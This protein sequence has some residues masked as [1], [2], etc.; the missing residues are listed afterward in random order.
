M[1]CSKYLQSFSQ[2][3]MKN[4]AF[5]QAASP[6]SK[7][8][9]TC[10]LP[11]VSPISGLNHQY[12]SFSKI[13]ILV[14][15]FLCLSTAFLPL[16]TATA[17]AT[18][19]PAEPVNLA[20]LLQK[21]LSSNHQIRAAA[22]QSLNTIAPEVK[23][24]VLTKA[25]SD[26]NWKIQAVAAYNL[27]Q[28]GSNARSAI[29]AL[30]AALDSP[31]PDVRFTVAK[32]LGQIGSEVAVP[33]LA[34]ALE[35]KDENVRMAAAIALDK[36]GPD[37]QAALPVL[38]KSLRDGNWFVRSHAAA[39]FVRLAANSKSIFP[40]LLKRLAKSTPDD[41]QIDDSRGEDQIPTVVAIEAL[42]EMGPEIVPDLLKSLKN[43][44]DMYYESSALALISLGSKT[45][46]DK[47]VELLIQT[48][49]D[50]DD[51]EFSKHLGLCLGWIGSKAAIPSLV[52]KKD[53]QALGLIGF[54]IIL[55]QKYVDY[56]S[57]KERL[58]YKKVIPTLAFQLK[59]EDWQVRATAIAAMALVSKDLA[60]EM[61]IIPYLQS[62]LGD[63]DRRVRRVVLAALVNLAD[64]SS[65]VTSELEFSEALISVIKD[66]D[67]R[68]QRSAI[69]LLK[70]IR[71]AAS[72]QNNLA[73]LLQDNNPALRLAAATVIEP[74][75]DNFPVMLR[76]FE[77][78]NQDI[79]LAAALNL[80]DSGQRSQMAR[81][82]LV[83]TV[84][85][86]FDVL[87]TILQ[88]LAGQDEDIRGSALETLGLYGEVALPALN[89]A[90]Q[91]NNSMVRRSAVKALGKIGNAA[92]PTLIKALHDQDPQVRLVA[93]STLEG[94]GTSTV[95]SALTETLQDKDPQVCYAASM[96]L[97]KK[98]IKLLDQKDLPVSRVAV[99]TLRSISNSVPEA[100]PALIAALHNDRN[101]AAAS[102]A[103]REIHDTIKMAY[104]S[105][106]PEVRQAAGEALVN[107]GNATKSALI[108]LLGDK[109]PQVRYKAAY[110]LGA[111]RIPTAVAALIATLHDKDPEVRQAAGEALEQIG[112]PGES[113]LI[114]ML[115]EKDLQAR[116]MAVSTLRE[117]GT[118]AAVPALIETLH[119]SNPEVRDAVWETLPIVLDRTNKLD[120]FKPALFKT[121]HDQNP[122]VRAGGAAVLAQVLVRLGRNSSN[123]KAKSTAGITKALIQA[124]PD[125]I[126]S[127][128]TGDTLARFQVMFALRELGSAARPAIPNLRNILADENWLLRY[129]AALTL[130]KINPR[131]VAIAPVLEEIFRDPVR[132]ELLH[133]DWG[134]DMDR[135]DL[136]ALGKIGSVQA[137]SAIINT[138]Q[139][140]DK[141][142]R[143]GWYWGEARVGPIPAVQTLIKVGSKA[144]PSLMNALKN[145][146]VRFLAS[147]T[148]G[149]LGPQ[150]ITYLMPVIQGKAEKE[151]YLRPIFQD[152]DVDL[153]RSAVYALGQI[154]LKNHAAKNACLQKLT[155]IM[156]YQNEHP[157]VRWMAAAFLMKLGKLDGSYFTSRNM[158]KPVEKVCP[159]PAIGNQ[160]AHFDIYTARCLYSII[161]G[162]A[163][164]FEIVQLVRELLIK[165]SSAGST[166]P[167]TQPAAT[168]R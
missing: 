149:Q 163:G 74:S 32:A 65:M 17:P 29:P 82:L 3:V 24:P 76:Y 28:I 110:S 97:G 61:G 167:P 159:V 148:L 124:L 81:T 108:N 23:I 153:R 11:D 56:F 71:S 96:A 43:R 119:D 93:V 15:V 25:L 113:A 155:T 94:I 45:G 51:S 64:L 50:A 2:K 40:L 137:L 150:V 156:N 147:F 121:L 38:Q 122:E 27:G 120:T 126:I 69:A 33:P 7:S 86:R 10:I 144:V 16:C 68:N 102:N 80:L 157:D 164:S 145:E 128:K 14:V 70:E 6:N 154:C 83:Q 160:G 130:I 35:D 138:L 42:A 20:D 57:P 140:S 49:D 18:P 79:R 139:L 44:D 54:K 134:I 112:K 141:E 168:G 31:N 52:T 125:L 75:E 12:F 166:T 55:E 78:E 41:R 104:K 19:T 62:S 9:G 85:Q 116:L 90:M 107:I 53:L 123:G 158:P 132:G 114:K 26:P 84:Q 129:W 4:L 67:T 103:I 39:A 152:K 92:E 63:Q 151:N 30:T 66:D 95:F 133:V 98:L 146:N 105:A 60:G 88:I 59:N 8:S 91:D 117:M 99:S 136:D 5:L 77:D 89:K 34:G 131:E 58:I 72:V 162:G 135:E 47:V 73:K 22:S 48:L 111:I 115:G 127:L 36:M 13:L 143:Y 46:N 37:A 161:E 142:L 109:D 101:L 1:V 87:S 106:D 118:A 165:Q 100:L 21:I